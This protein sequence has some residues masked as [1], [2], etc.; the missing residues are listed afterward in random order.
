MLKDKVKKALKIEEI[1][2]IELENQRLEKKIE[3]IHEQINKK[4]EF[5]CGVVAQNG[6]RLLNDIL[7]REYL[8]REYL[9]REYLLL[10]DKPNILI[11]GFYGARNFGDELMLR[12]VLKY[13]EKKGIRTTILLSDNYDL[14]AS[15]YAPH[16]VIHF[17]KHSSD[18]LALIN[19]FNVVIWGGGA[20][21]DDHEY[22]FKSGKPCLAYILNTVSKGIIKNGGKVVV[23]GVSSNKKLEDPRY[24]RD[25][26]YIIDGSKY[27]SL[28][29]TNSF[30]TLKKAGIEVNGIRL[31]DDLAL[32]ELSGLVGKEK[33]ADAETLV[34]GLVCILTE[35]TREII[36]E[37]IIRMIEH[38]ES[39]N[40]KV[41]IELIPF[42]NYCDNDKKEFKKIM[43]VYSFNK[44]V[45]ELK[46][47][48]EEIDDL[49]EVIHG[50]DLIISMRYH[51]TLVASVLGIRTLSLDYSTIHRHYYNKTSY[52]KEKYNKMLL[53]CD[54]GSDARTFL[55]YVDELLE[56]DNKES[57]AKN[58]EDI[59]K[60]L[61][62][63]LD[64]ALGDL[65]N[66]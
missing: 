5:F 21:L 27:F 39:K 59:R 18:I 60:S 1:E 25:L 52:I 13:F 40:K 16:D 17:P 20:H 30:N 37:Y 33:S 26:Q 50:C 8:F 12:S 58:L 11:C 48:M 43:E 6:E 32:Y 61:A 55:K 53:R 19:N 28:R 2:K 35:H 23:L 38:L 22:V 62:S 34:I 7:F 46:D 3:T 66:N 42:Y 63:E 65:K 51:A 15:I 64:I 36:G 29:D 4:T 14:D 56:Q 47:Y 57:D 54:F 49:V 10:K 44:D 31:I 41:H 45:V 9:S 24:L